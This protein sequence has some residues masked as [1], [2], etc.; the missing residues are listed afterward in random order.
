MATVTGTG[1]T[2]SYQFT[3]WEHDGTGLLYHRARY[4]SP[5]IQRFLSEDSIGFAGGDANLYA[6]VFNS[7]TNFTDPSG[8][9]VY[10][11]W[12]SPG[13]NSSESGDSPPPPDPWDTIGFLPGGGAF[14][15]GGLGAKGAAAAAAK[16][17]QKAGQQLDRNGLTKAGRALQKHGDRPNSAFP[18]STGTASERN[19]Q[20]QQLLEGI[21][22]SSNRTSGPNKFGGTDIFDNNT[23]RGVRFN[24]DGTMK[25][26][27]EP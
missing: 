20:G 18:K 7:P 27:L 24:A 6:Y 5:V 25:G 26:F 21:L 8:L 1:S 9:F 12:P 2:N 15:P 4:Y 23:G 17:F 3:G 22:N 10:P 11:G 19:Q 13:G 16:A 14:G